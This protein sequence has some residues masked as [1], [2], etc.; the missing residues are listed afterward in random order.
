MKALR[1]QPLT[2]AIQLSLLMSLPGLAAAQDAPAE[3][4]ASGKATTLDTI[5]VTGSRIKR[6]EIETASPVFQIDRAAIDNSGALTIGDFIQDVPS[7]SGAAT[8]PS[9]NNG[10][11]DGSATVSLRGLGE[12]RTLLLVNGRRIVTQDVNSIPMAMV[13]RVEILKDG[14]SAIYGSDAIGGVVNFILKQNF[15]GIET[16]VNYGVSAEDDGKREGI[17]STIGLSG[18]RG[19]LIISANYNK[20]EEVRSADRD[21]SEFALTLYAGVVTVGGSSRAPNGRYVIP[22]AISGIDCDGNPATAS[23]LTR[24]EGQAGTDPSHFRCFDSRTDLFNYQ[25]VGNLQLTP[26]ERTGLFVSGNYDITDNV[27]GY[28]DA[29]VNKTRSASQIAPLP[30]DGRPANDNIVLSGDSIYNPWGVDVIDSRLRLSRIGNRRF[31]FRTDVSQFTGGLRGAFGDSSWSWDTSA[32]A[33]TLKQSSL[34]TGYLLTSALADAVGPSFIDGD[35]VARCGTPSAPI[36]NCVPVDFFGAPPDASTPA[37]QAALA[38]L[39]LISPT[40]VNRTDLSMKGFQANVDGDLFELPAGTVQAAFGVEWRKENLRFSPDFLAVIN[41]ANFTCLISSEACTS[42]TSGSITTKEIYGEILVPVLK[43]VAFAKSLD[44]TIGTRWS[45]YDTEGSGGSDSE[46]TTNSKLGVEW[47]LNDQLMLRSTYAQVFR[48]PRITDLFQGNFASS[49]SFTDPCNGFDG[50]VDTAACTNVPTDGS[51]GQTDTQLSAIKGG[52]PN[53]KPEE[54]SV[55]TWGVVYE[56]TWLENFS[57]TVDVWKVQLDDTIGLYGTQTILNTCFASTA[58]NPSP[59]CALFSRDANGEIIRLFDINANIGETRTSGVDFGVKYRFDTG[60]GTFR[61]SLDATYITEY[62][63][64]VIFDGEQVAERN[65]A[66][67]F[68]SPAFGGDGNY[69]R[70]R[71]LGTLNW[72]LGNFD[73]QWTSRY[74]SGFD[75]GSLRPEGPCASVGSPPQDPVCTFR[76]GS[77]TYHNLAVGFSLPSWHTKFRVGV[78]NVGDKQP[79]IVYQNNSLNGNTDERTF[80]TVGRYYWAS[81]TIKF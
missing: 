73:A 74:I 44:L 38:A 19:N 56:P 2:K 29:F 25:A 43:D 40:A 32:S 70:V 18:D 28:L 14:A 69:S 11:G 63:V 8:N 21:Y 41:P 23:A 47:R 34:S 80:D 17:S 81:A 77:N 61:T 10:G 35:G 3:Q 68:L 50:S 6:T 53:L 33:G 27:T 66:G 1:H 78:D 65:N 12:D 36:A 13:E 51:F 72:N 45:D 7:M 4:P 37:G 9:V 16:T 60:F 52:N 54:G 71:A 31:E 76:R 67:T 62:D 79:P 30:F 55:F 75:V 42:P 46:R 26:Q 22:D 57:T 64:K 5:T 59:F 48:T 20:Q 15:D 58:A 39:A 49:D 24:I